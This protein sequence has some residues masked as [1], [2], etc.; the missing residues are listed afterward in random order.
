MKTWVILQ[1]IIFD[2]GVM[3]VIITTNII[4]TITIT[5]VAITKSLAVNS[6]MNNMMMKP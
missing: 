4:V 2:Y 1:Q 5:T 3:I 6:D